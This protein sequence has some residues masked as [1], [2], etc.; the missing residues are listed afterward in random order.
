[1][2]R[3]SRQFEEWGYAHPFAF[4]FALMLFTFYA[5]L[6]AIMAA[7]FPPRLHETQRDYI[8]QLV[9]MPVLLYVTQTLM[10]IFRRENWKPADER[11][12]L[13]LPTLRRHRQANRT[14]S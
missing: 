10:F 14:E 5:L 2:L 7:Q 6:T 1:M 4:A 8:R 12:E 3:R 13:K 9:T 11:K